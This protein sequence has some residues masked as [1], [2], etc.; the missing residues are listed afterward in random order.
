LPKGNQNLVDTA[1]PFTFGGCRGKSM[2]HIEMNAVNKER[3]MCRNLLDA[4]LNA[5]QK[6]KVNYEFKYLHILSIKIK[7][8]YIPFR[9]SLD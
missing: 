9:D 2:Q 4:F 7:N 3:D 1:Q 8:K 6:I 5:T